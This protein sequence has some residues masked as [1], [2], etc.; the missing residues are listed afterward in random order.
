M[1]PI[2]DPRFSKTRWEG[3]RK[4]ELEE[5]VRIQRNEYIKPMVMFT[6]AFLL[7]PTIPVFGILAESGATDA[8]IAIGV[9]CLAIGV[10]IVI[11]LIALVITCGLFGTGAGPLMLGLLWLAAIFAVVFA[12]NSFL[13]ISGCVS[14]L[15]ILA[16]IAGLVAWMFDMDKVES[17][18]VAVIT[19]L[20]WI[21]SNIV[22]Y[23]AMMN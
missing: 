2:H 22:I 23:A 12:F 6:V 3:A 4:A 15:I 13:P 1:S 10:A 16:I 17:V 5:S 20:I 19:W 14:L 7:F 21:G 11:G 8:A 18:T 9:Y